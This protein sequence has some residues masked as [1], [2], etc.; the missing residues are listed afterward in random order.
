[1][2]MFIGI[3]ITLFMG[4]FAFYSCVMVE[5]QK[6]GEKITLPWEKK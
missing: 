5:E 4:V 3:V 6:R 2:D 1:M